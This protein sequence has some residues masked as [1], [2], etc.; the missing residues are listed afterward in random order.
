MNFKVVDLDASRHFVSVDFYIDGETYSNNIYGLCDV[1]GRCL[2]DT[3]AELREAIRMYG[4]TNY[5]PK[6][7][8][9]KSQTLV[10]QVF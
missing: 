1:D 6:G 7:R 3:P 8:E 9:P 5:Q 4:A 2:M 10:G